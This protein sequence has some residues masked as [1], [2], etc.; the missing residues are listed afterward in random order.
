MNEKQ[1][2]QRLLKK[3]YLLSKPSHD[4]YLPENYEKTLADALEI[5]DVMCGECKKQLTKEMLVDSGLDPEKLSIIY[6][7]KHR[8][9]RKKGGGKMNKKGMMVVEAMFLGLFGSA[10]IAAI[11]TTPQHRIKMGIKRCEAEGQTSCDV[12]VPELTKANLLH[13]IR[14][15]GVVKSINDYNI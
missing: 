10:I 7:N 5:R 6:Y 11:L 14:D 13:Y 4:A 8:K 9:P 2:I 3:Y 1:Y 12:R 15:D